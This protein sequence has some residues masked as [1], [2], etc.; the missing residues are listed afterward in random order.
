[1]IDADTL[2]EIFRLDVPA[3]ELVLRTSVIY[4]L[5]L[6]GMRLIARRESGTLEL[7]DLL[8]V[9]LIADGVQNGMSG[10]YGSVTGGI[11]VGGTILAWNFALDAAT[12]VSPVARRLLRPAPL[13]LVRDGRIIRQNLRREFISP[14]ELMTLLRAKDV[15]DVADVRR[16][17]LEPNG[18]LSVRKGRGR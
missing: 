15:D 8:M 3:L 11:I 6:A 18:E 16:A 7:P 17:F 5:L 4:L 2:D 14:D 12:Y 13:L 1:M 9:V 10:E